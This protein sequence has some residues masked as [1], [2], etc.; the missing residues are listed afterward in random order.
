MHACLC[1]C[2]VCDFFVFSRHISIPS[3]MST[4]IPPP[5]PH[6]IY[7]HCNTAQHMVMYIIPSHDYC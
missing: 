3:D 7:I 6:L 5:P 1:V 4:L 2:T